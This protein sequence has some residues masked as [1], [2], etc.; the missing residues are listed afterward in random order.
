MYDISQKNEAIRELQKYLRTIEGGRTEPSSVTVDGIYGDNTRRAV[1]EYQARAGMPIT[2]ITDR[3]TWDGIY[4]EHLRVLDSAPI[5]LFVFPLFPA[6]YSI[7]PGSGG[8]PV[9]FLK[10]ILAELTQYYDFAPIPDSD[11]YDKETE[12]AVRFFQ[13]INGLDVTGALDNE[14]RNRLV[15]EYNRIIARYNG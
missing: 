9:R 1:R 15:S 3:K 7:L 14:T 6:N 10:L 13:S 11:I 2:G 12:D 8:A 4:L 5:G